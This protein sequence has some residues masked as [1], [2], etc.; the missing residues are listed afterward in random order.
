MKK[1]LQKTLV[2]VAVGAALG[3]VSHSAMAAGNLLPAIKVGGGWVSVVSYVNT[4]PTSGGVFVH[5]THQSKDITSSDTACIHVDGRSATT[6]NDLTTSVLSTPGGAVGAVFPAADTVGGTL[7]NPG[8]LTVPTSEGFLVL[9]NYDGTN[10]VGAAGTLTSDAIVFNLASGFMYSTRA[11]EVTHTTASPAGFVGIEA[12]GLAFGGRN[13]VSAAGTNNLLSAVAG[14]NNTGPGVT[15][16]LA[17]PGTSGGSLTRFSFLPPG[18][19]ATTGA[20]LIPTNRATN[21]AAAGADDALTTNLV[22]SGYRA[23]ALFAARMDAAQGFAQGIYDRLEGA[24]SLSIIN[25]VTCVAQLTPAQITGNS[26]PSFIA[27]GGW[28]NLSPTALTNDAG[29]QNVSDS[30]VTYK[31]EFA[32]GYG[33]SIQPLNQQWHAK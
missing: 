23:R 5:A 17:A 2:A 11:L 32:T 9:E 16:L 29:T 30:A 28:F 7:I 4:Q 24:R 19:P 12:P 8:A 14:V 3:A 31:V 21:V 13:T 33:L 10:A 25:P 26:V 20:Y 15:A 22:A 27:N 6:I 18:A 1:I